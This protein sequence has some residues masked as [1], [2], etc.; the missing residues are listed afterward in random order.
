MLG[1]YAGAT[2]EWLLVLRPVSGCLLRRLVADWTRER[3]GLAVVACRGGSVRR[4]R[5]GIAPRRVGGSPRADVTRVVLAVAVAGDCR[6][7]HPGPNGSRRPL[8]IGPGRPGDRRRRPSLR[9]HHHAARRTGHRR[10]RAANVRRR[11]KRRRAAEHRAVRGRRAAIGVACTGNP[12]AAAVG[13][14]QRRVPRRERR[15]FILRSRHVH[16]GRSRNRIAD[17]SVAGGPGPEAGRA[18]IAT[19]AGPRQHGCRPSCLCGAALWL[20][21]SRA[22]FLAGI[23]ASPSGSRGVAVGSRDARFRRSRWRRSSESG[24][25]QIR[26]WTAARWCAMSIRMELARVSF[27]LLGEAPVFGIGIG[28]FYSQSGREIRDPA[29]SAIYPRENA[30]NNF[31]QHPRRARSCR[32]RAASRRFSPALPWGRAFAPSL[33]AHR[34]GAPQSDWGRF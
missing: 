32:P 13:E 21:G 11:R 34:A 1:L 24:H 6:L 22:A 4:D 28:R 7:R 18:P 19:A 12:R 9:R 30:H 5:G 16:R 33:S 14:D 17:S 8:L 31:L 26:S 23:A 20:S 27:R 25:F 29:V 15:G 10:A 3:G 2:A